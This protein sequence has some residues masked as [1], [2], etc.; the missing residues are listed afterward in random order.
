MTATRNVKPSPNWVAGENQRNGRSTTPSTALR[1][2]VSL[3]VN[4]GRG[5]IELEPSELL[6]ASA[7]ARRRRRSESGTALCLPSR[8]K[9]CCSGFIAPRQ[10]LRQH[11]TNLFQHWPK[12]LRTQS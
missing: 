3:D 6:N 11:L 4:F 12:G 8:H 1:T 10:I 9:V 5:I 7:G 2:L